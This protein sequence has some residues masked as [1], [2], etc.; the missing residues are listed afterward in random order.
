MAGLRYSMRT[1]LAGVVV[2]AIACAAVASPSRW[3]AS[4]LLSSVLFLLALAVLGGA[5]SR[6]LRRAGFVGFAWLGVVYL[7]LVYA[8]WFEKNIAP[9]IPTTQI[10]RPWFNRLQQSMTPV[11]EGAATVVPI[12]FDDNETHW[13]VWLA[14]GG[15]YEMTSTGLPSH[16]SLDAIVHSLAAL[17]LGAFGAMAGRWFYASAQRNG[18]RTSANSSDP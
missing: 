7:S 9:E 14:G 8:P 16:Q 4:G 1:L 17:L 12:G 10:S 2:I 3:W 11:V 15:S 13:R 5:F 6:G 18:A